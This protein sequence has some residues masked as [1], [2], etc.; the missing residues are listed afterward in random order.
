MELICLG[1]VA[2]KDRKPLDLISICG[3][4]QKLRAS[5]PIVLVCG[6]SAEVGKTT[7]AKNIIQAITKQGYRVAA[8]KLSGTGRMRDILNLQQAGAS[9]A[10]D[11]PEVG[12]AT[13]YTSPERFT[14]AS[15]TL[16][17]Y[18]NMHKPDI[19]VAEAG[20][21]VIEAN[22]P[23]FLADKQL[24]KHVKAICLVAGDVMGMMGTVTYLQRYASN[25]PIYL[26]DPKGRNPITTRERVAHELPG[27]TCFNS[28]DPPEVTS[29]VKQLMKGTQ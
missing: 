6:T 17:H 10:L 5:A 16:I 8:S 15:H 4:H 12:L 13:T 2:D 9:T 26:A 22:I 20:G 18:L 25:I 14:P 24:M 1:L 11:F 19:I 23:T 3:G 7:T 27:L 29:I 28:L 21:D